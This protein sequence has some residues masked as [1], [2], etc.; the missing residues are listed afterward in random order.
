MQNG[1]KPLKLPISHGFSVL[2]GAFFNRF[3]TDAGGFADCLAGG[4]S[5][6]V[7]VNR[8]GMSVAAFERLAHFFTLAHSA[9]NAASKRSI[10]KPR[11]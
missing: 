6:P 5:L 7:V 9:E 1:G 11:R 10:G 4:T 3:P 2:R 8:L